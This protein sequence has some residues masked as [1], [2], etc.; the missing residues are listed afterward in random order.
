MVVKQKMLTNPYI[1]T[2]LE[3]RNIRE[4]SLYIHKEERLDWKELQDVAKRIAMKLFFKKEFKNIGILYDPDVDGLYSGYTIENYLVRA[5]ID[6]EKI[7]R[8]MNPNKVHGFS[9]DLVNFV[10]END[11]DLLFVVDAGSSDM[12]KFAMAMPNT[13]V[14]ILDH[15]EYEIPVMPESHQV[16]KLNVHD[17]PHLPALSGCGVVYRFVEELN[18]FMEL[19]IKM[20]EIFVGMTVLSDSCDMDV[21]ENRYYVSQAYAN[22]DFNAFLS[23]F[24]ESSFYGSNISLF[25][26]KIIPYLNALIRMGYHEDAM[27]IVNN[28]E[29]SSLRSYIGQNF[30]KV[31]GE[32]EEAIQYIRDSSQ[33]TVGDGVA[34]LLR[35]PSTEIKTLNG[36]VASKIMSELKRSTLVLVLSEQDGK[37]VWKGSFR[38]LN[39]GN[40]VLKKFGLDCRG[41]DKACGVTA[42]PDQLRNFL[43]NLDFIPDTISEYDLEMSLHE[44]N[45]PENAQ[46]F[47]EFNEY[48]SGN[49]KPI[50]IKVT[51]TFTP[52]TARKFAR[53]TSGKFFII[54]LGNFEITDFTPTPI[55][56]IDEL[57][58]T[59]NFSKFNP[60][61][62]SRIS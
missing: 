54:S 52:T 10:N 35:R 53:G 9:D 61:S 1:Q 40:K 22:N 21:P 25:S 57:I 38:G 16:T 5:K 18:R 33:I 13:E 50:S 56:D 28:M 4:E 36:L 62:V 15:H 11:I 20:Y 19:H 8:F 45:K 29:N 17:Y 34:I 37:N 49:I 46:A 12:L 6:R 48:A 58:V 42:T 24:K 60:Y 44:L 59:I 14:I 32:Q 41:H 26:F 43:E 51:D 7:H 2:V 23:T 30:T 55:K 39:Y 31:K 47:S 27:K 3:N